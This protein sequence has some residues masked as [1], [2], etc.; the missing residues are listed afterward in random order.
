M[1]LVPWGLHLACQRQWN[2][3]AAMGSSE[4]A[5]SP[6]GQRGL[7]LTTTAVAASTSPLPIWGGERGGQRVFTSDLVAW[8]GPVA[9]LAHV[10]MF[11]R[12]RRH[13]YD[14]PL[15]R[16]AES[17]VS[18]F[19]CL[20]RKSAVGA[21]YSSTLWCFSPTTANHNEAESL[22]TSHARASSIRGCHAA[23]ACSLDSCL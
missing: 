17:S 8:T 2:C 9:A 20:D 3:P 13:C 14:Q 21:S 18:P 6:C 10:S 11:S 15:P 7:T 22:E 23:T 1:T 4:R 5:V 16:S 19:Q 12:E